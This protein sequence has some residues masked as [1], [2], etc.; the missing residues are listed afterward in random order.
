MAACVYFFIG[1]LCVIVGS[2]RGNRVKRTNN[3]VIFF[4]ICYMC[5]WYLLTLTIPLELITI[6]N[7]GTF[8]IPLIRFLA[9]FTIITIFTISTIFAMKKDGLDLLIHFLNCLAMIVFL[10]LG[11]YSFD[12]S[13]R[14]MWIGVSIA[15]VVIIFVH[16]IRENQHEHI[17]NSR[18]VASIVVFTTIYTL[19]FYTTM[20]WGPLCENM[21][22]YETQEFIMTSMDIFI[23]AIC[24]PLIVH[25]SW[26]I[27]PDSQPMTNPG[28]LSSIANSQPLEVL[29]AYVRQQHT[30]PA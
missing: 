30:R 16:V 18:F 3:Q 22:G 4:F 29:E 10:F 21:I 14:R 7:D 24:A 15:M 11:V 2:N 28:E 25:Y 19:F 17:E 5:I 1:L 12:L 23:S 9:G 8:Y 27:V 6:R 20:I 13:T 26:A